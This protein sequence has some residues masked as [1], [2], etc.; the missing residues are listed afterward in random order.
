[1]TMT[2]IAGFCQL[3]IFLMAGCATSP[4]Q[5][6]TI[7]LGTP[8]ELRAGQSAVV[9]GGLTVAFD[10]VKSD[11]RCPAAATCISAGDAVVGLTLAS[12]GQTRAEREVHSDV[13]SSRVSFLE[14]TVA[15]QALTPYPISSAQSIRPEE[16]V[17]RFVV[18]K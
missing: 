8:F 2:R 7:A 4:M 10:R 16:Y 1:M 3:T 15:L 5:P 9:A 12:T 17:A 11:S 18:T 13:G 14:Y 6:T